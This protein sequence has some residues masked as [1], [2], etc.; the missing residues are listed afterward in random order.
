MFGLV[1]KCVKRP[2]LAA[3]SLT[4]VPPRV[5]Y[6]LA[7]SN[8]YTSTGWHPALL[9]TCTWVDWGLHCSITSMPDNTLKASSFWG[10]KTLI[11]YEDECA[12]DNVPDKTQ[13]R[14]RRWHLELT[15]LGWF[16]FWRR[17]T[18]RWTLCSLH[19]GTTHWLPWLTFAQSQRTPLYQ[20]YAYQLLEVR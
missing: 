9:V 5:R 10:L 11:R 13:G 7:H 12:P 1:T 15:C 14:S 16:G 19:A 2:F 6:A 17:T 18:E 20:K 4:T 3:R 8:A